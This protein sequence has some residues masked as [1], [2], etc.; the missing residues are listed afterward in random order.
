[1]AILTQETAKM[2]L[3]NSSPKDKYQVWDMFDSVFPKGHAIR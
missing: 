3:A 2:F 1:M